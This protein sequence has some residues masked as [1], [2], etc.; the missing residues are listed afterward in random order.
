MILKHVFME[1][2]YL[3]ASGDSAVVAELPARNLCFWN[4]F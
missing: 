2:S 3:K 4:R 1:V